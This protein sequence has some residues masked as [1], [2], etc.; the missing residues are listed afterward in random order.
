MADY[1]CG[2][3]VYNNTRYMVC[4]E[5]QDP[6]SGLS[7]KYPGASGFPFSGSL[8]VKDGRGRKSHLVIIC[9]PLKGYSAMSNPLNFVKGE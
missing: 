3:W 6:K 7:A 4:P 9:S 2:G 8:E 5:P 1:M